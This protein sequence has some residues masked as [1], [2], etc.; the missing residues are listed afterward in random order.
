[1]T[2]VFILLFVA[3]LLT[4]GAGAQE[5]DFNYDDSV[6][7]R[8]APV[9]VKINQSAVSFQASLYPEYYK[10]N[11]AISD[12][13]WVRQNDSVVMAFWEN[14]GDSILLTLSE[15]SGLDWGEPS[16]EMI[17]LRYYPS[18][19]NAD[20]LV[21]PLGGMRRGILTEACP[22][23]N[24]QEL[25]IIYQLAHRMLGQAEKSGDPFY[26]SMAAH[27]LMQPG[28]FRRDNLA[29]LLALV[30]A[31]R[32]IGLDSTY[33]AYH[34][35]FWKQRH[36]GREVFEQYLLSEWILSPDHPL[37][38][39][40]VEEPYTS[41]LVSSTR[42]RRRQVA[43]A[44]TRKRVYIEGLPIKGQLGFSVKVNEANRLVVDKIDPT[45]LAFACG[46]REGDEI[47]KV[48][49]VRPRNQKALI[50]MILEGLD[51]GGATL[52]INRDEI[53]QTVLIQP[54]D[55]YGG[56]DPYYWEEMDDSIDF[57]VP[58]VEDSTI[59]PEADTSPPKNN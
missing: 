3:L 13:R 37:A 1:M 32:I 11:S 12:L 22:Y 20:P 56:E 38:R 17:L 57:E 42:P 53:V 26:R 48:E 18:V 33:D 52:E 19:G 4:P 25:N 34:S 46:L 36:P 59:V 5:Y 40:V 28:P 31:Q 30:T 35:A 44:D 49:A 2:R 41:K 10:T 9:A 8:T 51:E 23:G 29:M 27:P 15:L 54:L 6:P 55:L 58:A 43:T 39:W 21:V 47:R 50:E 24:R 45:R 16:F 7:A 14:F